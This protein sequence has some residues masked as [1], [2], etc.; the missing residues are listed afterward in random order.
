MF[1]KAPPT[2]KKEDE[3]LDEKLR[4]MAWDEYIGQD[5]VKQKLGIIIEAAKKRE[6]PIEHLLFYGNSGLGKTTLAYVVA[7]VMGKGVK[8]CSGPTLEK[9]GDLAS[10]LTNLGDGEVL[11][12]DECHRIQRLVAEMLYSALE[13]FKLHLILGKGPMART[14]E[15][16]LPRFTLIGA[17][18]R[19]SLLPSPFR[20]RFGG[21]FQLDFY[22]KEDLEKI[23]K[24]SARILNVA[25]EEEAV[26][27]L[28]TRSRFTPR[29]ANRLLKRIRDFA[30]VEGSKLIT[31]EM[32]EKGLK[33][34][35]I[36]ESGL[37]PEDR[38]I[39][40]YIIERFGGGPVGIKALASSVAEEP[41]T[42]LDIYEPYLMQLGFI[43]RTPQG[44]VATS[45]AYK[46][47]GIAKKQ[48]DLI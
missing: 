16:A 33:L 10:L 14:M 11:F 36:D 7:N 30:T 2:V 34:L 15:L 40:R 31:R 45:L 32:A 42:I 13:D 3:T 8:T 47:L 17:T 35:E 41:E 37:E 39:L 24:R 26:G 20:N 25:I 9:T 5:K 22:T 18:T 38:K 4:P 43:E 21:I 29:I 6:E 27:L 19:L 1:V 28:A 46:H 23:I 44:R 48:K 12:V